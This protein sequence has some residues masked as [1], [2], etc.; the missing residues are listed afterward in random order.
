M[1][2]Y[3]NDHRLMLVLSGDNEAGFRV[4]EMIWGLMLAIK[5]M[6]SHDEFRNC[7]FTLRWNNNIIGSII[8]AQTLRNGL[9]GNSSSIS[10]A[11]S[12]TELSTM[13][14][15]KRRLN[16]TLDF[17]IGWELADE[18]L[19]F[20]EVMMT[21]I[22][23]YSDLAAHDLNKRVDN[24][25]F[26]TAWPPY[27]TNF[28]LRSVAPAPIWFTYVVVFEVLTLLANWYFR[29]RESR[30][31]YVWILTDGRYVG[32]AVLIDDRTHEL[33]DH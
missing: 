17:K 27:G 31:A 11:R 3:P 29:H 21:L 28:E 12:Y 33:T 26:A 2:K 32:H 20:S 24:D 9:V 19:E 5:H 22:S 16:A 6:N 25:A 15:L 1:A 8:F 30:S 10:H 4:K 14:A 13:P 7:R 23:G 18:P